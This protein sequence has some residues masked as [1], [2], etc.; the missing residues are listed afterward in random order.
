MEEKVIIESRSLWA[1][2]KKLVVTLLLIA[3][4][5]TA[6]AG[7]I[8]AVSSSSATNLYDA[9]HTREYT[10]GYL[11]GKYYWSSVADKDWKQFEGKYDS[12]RKTANSFEIL[13]GL[14]VC[15]L[16]LSAILFVIYLYCSKMQITVTDKR[17]YGKTAFGKRVD[18][19]LDSVSAVGTSAFRG[20]AVATSAGKIK[21]IRMEKRDEVHREISKLLVGRQDTQ[22]RKE[23]TIPAPTASNADELKKYKELLDSGII[24]QEEFD[25]KK[26]HLLGL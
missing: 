12:L 7:I 17:V 25:A 10:K 4:L 18:L 13:F 3:I 5:F 9:H 6:I 11:S 14:G 8:A 23:E 19:P 21:F 1:K 15:A 16:I 24:T 20:L 26:K 2:R 22:A